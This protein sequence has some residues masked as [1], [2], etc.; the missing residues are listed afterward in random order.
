M[1]IVR[2]GDGNWYF[3][4]RWGEPCIYALIGFVIV[5]LGIALIILIIWLIGL[6]MRKTNNLAFLTNIGKKK[7][8]KK[9][10]PQVETAGAEE[11]EEI[12]PEVRAAIVAAIAAYYIED[13][14]KCEFRVKRI[15]KL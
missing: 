13:K 7:R 2:R 8:K 1:D 15:K 12:A 6:L 5:F 9:A 4:E 11:E 3:Q 10:E 14:P